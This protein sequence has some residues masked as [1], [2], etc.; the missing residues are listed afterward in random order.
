MEMIPTRIA[1][2]CLLAMTLS[3]A[4]LAT[5]ET[6]GVTA[7]IRPVQQ[8]KSAPDFALKDAAGKTVRLSDYRGRTVLLDFWASKCGGCVEEI[9]W[10]IEITETFAAK[11]LATV[12]VSEDIAYENLK[13]AEEAWTLVKPFV[14]DHKVP[15][16]VLMGDLQITA[17]YDIKALP[18]TYLIDRRGRVAAVYAG[19]VDR[20][21]LE[22]NIRTLL[23][24]SI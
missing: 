8:R 16:P 10:F 3:G 21:N 17:S 24:E 1:T 19:K 11:G 15:Y 4:G 2:A 6:N 22:A 18:L 23:A 13:G 5:A 14:R 20:A 9:P 12:G 7:T